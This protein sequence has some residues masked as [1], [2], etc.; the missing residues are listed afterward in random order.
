M[1]SSVPSVLQVETAV[2]PPPVRPDFGPE[3]LGAYSEFGRPE[4]MPVGSWLLFGITGVCHEETLYPLWLT[5][6]IA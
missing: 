2:R 4:T 3:F 5:R 1:Q 6:E